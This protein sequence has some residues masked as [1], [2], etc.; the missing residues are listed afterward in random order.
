MDAVLHLRFQK[1][2]PP[3]Q[4]RVWV[5]EGLLQAE[6]QKGEEGALQVEVRKGLPTQVQVRHSSPERSV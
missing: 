6:I 4:T 1:Q 5:Q 2:G 3:T